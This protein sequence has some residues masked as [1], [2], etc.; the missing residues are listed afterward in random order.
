LDRPF[1]Q[2]T[3][4]L[5]MRRVLGGILGL[6]LVLAACA[7]PGA[8]GSSSG[9]GASGKPSGPIKVGFLAPTTGNAAASGQD[10][11]NGWSLYWK[12]NN[13]KAAGRDVQWTH[14]DTSSDPT[15]ALN[16]ARQFVEQQQV[17][18]LVGTLLADGRRLRQDHGYACVLPE[19]VGR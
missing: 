6:T 11:I 13:N 8:P 9:P 2:A 5:A 12:Q 3:R 4:G 10:M 16:K 18:M 14:E 17:D 7:P 15:V 1:E 19:L